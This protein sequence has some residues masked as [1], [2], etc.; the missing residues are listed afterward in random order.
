[1]TKKLVDSLVRSYPIVYWKEYPN[2]D[3]PDEY[4]VDLARLSAE[5]EELNYRFSGLNLLAQITE[6]KVRY[7]R[8]YVLLRATQY[9][10]VACF[11]GWKSKAI[12]NAMAWLSTHGYDLADYKCWARPGFYLQALEL[13]NKFTE[14][15]NRYGLH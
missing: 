14:R 12:A 5:L 9:V 6:V 2:I 1:M 8:M 4:Y 11:R 13:I 15:Y 3:I 7:G 10:K